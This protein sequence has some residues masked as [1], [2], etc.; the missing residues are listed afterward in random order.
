MVGSISITHQSYVKLKKAYNKAVVQ[1]KATFT[2]EGSELVVD[3]A[4]YLLQF[5]EIKLGIRK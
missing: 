2:F 4:K 5:M 3:Y 1:K